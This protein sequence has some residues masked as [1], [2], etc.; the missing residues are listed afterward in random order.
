MNI[1]ITEEERNSITKTMLETFETAKLTTEYNL[2]KDEKEKI[3]SIVLGSHK[4]YRYIFITEIATKTTLPEINAL[5]LQMKSNLPGAYDARSVAHKVVVPFEKEYLNNS[6]GGSNEPFLN[7]PARF[8]SL[9]ENNAVRSGKDKQELLTMIALLK[10]I[11]QEKAKIYLQYSFSLLLEK[12]KEEKNKEVLRLQT[13]KSTS[14]YQLRNLLQKLISQSIGGQ[15]LPLAIGTLLNEYISS[16]NAEDI[17]II[18]HKVNESGASSKEVG[19]IDIYSNNTLIATIEAKDKTFNTNDVE[20]AAQKAIIAG[21]DSFLF[22]YN[23]SK[24]S[25]SKKLEII[26][27]CKNIGCYVSLITFQDFMNVLLCFIH[28]TDLNKTYKT[29]NEII[30]DASMTAKVQKNVDSI[31]EDI[32][33]SK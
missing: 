31:F 16:I 24:L 22:I 25:N 8:T 23:N 21:L 3:K 15:S 29:M 5:A 19:D 4:T 20:H 17:S 1:K 2:T 9:S 7:K 14:T 33:K 32:S 30:K 18:V 6:L 12:I 10:D 27:A 26:N 28:S 11:Q 13:Q